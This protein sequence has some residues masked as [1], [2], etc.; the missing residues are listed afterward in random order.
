MDIP[1]NLTSIVISLITTAA[2]IITVIVQTRKNNATTEK[3][4]AE[5]REAMEVNDYKTYLLTLIHAYP[6][7]ADEIY[8]VAKHYFQELNGDSFVLPIFED[9]LE[10]Q[11]ADLPEWFLAAKKKHSY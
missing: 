4:A 5:T 7:K 3:T 1:P 6:F 2:T 11:R 8:S 10:T 9:W